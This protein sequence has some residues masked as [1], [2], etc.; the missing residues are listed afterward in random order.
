MSPSRSKN[1][2]VIKISQ[3]KDGVSGTPGQEVFGV[4]GSGKLG[5][6]VKMGGSGN[7]LRN[8]VIKSPD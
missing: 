5:K 7:S 8:I 4:P 3:K 1:S 6:G 2:K